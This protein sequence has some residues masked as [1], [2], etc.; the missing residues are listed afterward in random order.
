ML[1]LHST[2]FGNNTHVSL[3]F[4]FFP[5]VLTIIKTISFIYKINY[6]LD[7]MSNKKMQFPTLQKMDRKRTSFVELAHVYKYKISDFLLGSW[8]D[9]I[10]Q[11]I[12]IMCLDFSKWNMNLHGI[13]HIQD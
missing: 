7:L 2:T 5:I 1:S 8:L 3:Q 10:L 9:H 6:R 4:K 12:E 11:L 13:Y